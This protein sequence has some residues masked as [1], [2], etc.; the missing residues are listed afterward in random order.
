METKGVLQSKTIWANAVAF[1]ALIINKQWGVEVDPEIQVSLVVV[2]NFIMRLITKGPVSLK[3][4]K[5][6]IWLMVLPFL[7]GC[8]ALGFNAPVSVCSGIDNSLICKITNDNPEAAETGLLVVN[9]ALLKKDA[10]TAASA[11][12]TVKEMIAHIE[13]AGNTLTGSDVVQI[14]GS[15]LDEIDALMIIAGPYLLALDQN[16]LLN[17]FDTG[18]ILG[19]LRKHEALILAVMD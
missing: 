7:A 17:E 18:W 13:A 6:A 15:K 2:L 5:L 9:Y 8:A 1:I 3:G 16:V 4:N 19:H 11:L 10:Y 14:I 12:N